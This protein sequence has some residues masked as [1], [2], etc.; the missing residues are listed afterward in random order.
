MSGF[1]V[2]LMRQKLGKLNATPESIQTLSLW[3][4]HHQ[5]HHADEITATWLSVSI[6]YYFCFLF[7]GI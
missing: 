7:W 4:L 3:L 2:E 5:K 6:I 1:S